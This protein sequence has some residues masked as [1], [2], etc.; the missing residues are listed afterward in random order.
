MTDLP[1]KVKANFIT[2]EKSIRKALREL[3]TKYEYDIKNMI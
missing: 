2:R 1:P 3:H